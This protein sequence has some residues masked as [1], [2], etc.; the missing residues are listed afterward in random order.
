[1]CSGCCLIIGSVRF[2]WLF[3]M[4]REWCWVMWGRQLWH[5]TPARSNWM[6]SAY[7]LAPI[8]LMSWFRQSNR[9]TYKC[10][11]A[12]SRVWASKSVIVNPNSELFWA[13]PNVFIENIRIPNHSVANSSKSC[14]SWKIVIFWCNLK[15][16]CFWCGNAQILQTLVYRLIE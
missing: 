4:N 11:Q 3:T 14:T 12:V 8:F 2:V 16:P 13:V 7:Y 1:M 9:G 6:V 15:Y 10:A 5:S